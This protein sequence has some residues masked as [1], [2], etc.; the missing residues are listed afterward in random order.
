MGTSNYSDE[1][2]LDA[3]HQIAVRGVSGSGCFPAI[4]G[5]H[6]F[7]LQMDEA[8]RRPRAEEAGC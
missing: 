3:V 8:V 7:A 1:F 5:Q 2:K 6:A 4:G